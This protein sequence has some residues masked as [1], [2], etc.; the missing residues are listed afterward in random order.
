MEEHERVMEEVRRYQRE[1]EQEI[2]QLE[3]ELARKTEFLSQLREIFDKGD[4]FYDKTMYDL[5]IACYDEIINKE[6]VPDYVLSSCWNSK[7]WAL[8]HKN[9]HEEALNCF[10]KAILFNPENSNCW[11]GKGNS[12]F[13]LEKFEESV[14]C[15]DEAKM[16]GS[17]S[18]MSLENNRR[19]FIAFLGTNINEGNSWNKKGKEFFKEKKYCEAL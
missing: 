5:A 6:D 7:G 14:K 3:K 10:D 1:R 8:Y 12:L 13:K 19:A 18:D 15:Y 9:K 4:R 11:A 16:V 2:R 17:I